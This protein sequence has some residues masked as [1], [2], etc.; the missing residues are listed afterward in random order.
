MLRTHDYVSRAEL[1]RAPIRFAISP[2]PTML[3]LMRDAVQGGRRGTPAQWR[4]AIMARLRARH[5]AALAP[6][7]DRRT[8]G[9]PSLLDDVAAPMESIDEALQRIA[10]TS[11]Q[12]LIDATEGDLDVTPS[13]A[14]ESL[15]RDP[16]R[17]L[18]AYVDAMHR[19][20]PVLAPL[21]RQSIRLLER[22]AERLSAAID[23]GVPTSQMVNEL[24]PRVALVGDAL[25]LPPSAEPRRLK[26]GREGVTA[27][28][29]ITTSGTGTLSS[30]GECLVRFAYPVRKV[31]RALDDKVP[32][33][34]SLEALLG[35]SRTRVLQ[36]LDRPL[37]AGALA[38]IS[39]LDPSS[40]TYHL[41]ALESAGLVVRRRRGRNV[42]VHR[43]SLGTRLLSLYP[44]D[45]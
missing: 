18:R 31:W 27:T 13:S 35:T 10:A 19:A 14:W 25:L 39:R 16:D 9:W 24:F 28:P 43:T 21:W 17:W 40:L 6:L 38:E 22:D 23:R 41:D 37:T 29:I 1:D 33:P 34:A 26:V 15:R 3:G 20:W 4:K 44:E 32:P 7:A 30:P 36:R 45:A 8:T 11:G 2:I 12:K 5:I 42:I